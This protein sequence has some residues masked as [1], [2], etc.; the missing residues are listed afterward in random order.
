MAGALGMKVEGAEALLGGLVKAEEVTDV[1]FKV[2][3]VKKYTKA[4][5]EG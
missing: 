2:D 1:S 4:K 3:K 5:V